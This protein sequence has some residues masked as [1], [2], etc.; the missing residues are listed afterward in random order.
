MEYLKLLV[1][2]YRNDIK[3]TRTV[4]FYSLFLISLFIF[5]PRAHAVD[6]DRH[7]VVSMYPSFSSSYCNQ[8]SDNR[9]YFSLEHSIESMYR[10]Y[11]DANPTQP[12]YEK[13]GAYSWFENNNILSVYADNSVTNHKYDMVEGTPYWNH[14]NSHLWLSPVYTVSDCLAAGMNVQEIPSGYVFEGEYVCRDVG[15]NPDQPSDGILSP[16]AFDN[17]ICASYESEG[18]ADSV[19]IEKSKI[20]PYHFFLKKSEYLLNNKEIRIVSCSDDN[21]EETDCTYDHVLKRARKLIPNLPEERFHGLSNEFGVYFSYNVFAYCKMIP[22]EISVE[23][24]TADEVDCR[25]VNYIGTSESGA[26]LPPMPFEEDFCYVK[27]DENGEPEIS[28]RQWCNGETGENGDYK[29]WTDGKAESCD[30]PPEIKEVVETPEKVITTVEDKVYETEADS[31]DVTITTTT[32]KTTEDKETG[33]ISTTPPITITITVPKGDV[34]GGNGNN[35]GG[36]S[37]PDLGTVIPVGG[38]V[39]PFDF[40]EQSYKPNAEGEDP[41]YWIFDKHFKSLE[42]SPIQN[43]FGNMNPFGTGDYDFPVFDIDLNVSEDLNFGHYTI[44]LQAVQIG[45]KTINLIAILRSVILLLVALACVREI[46]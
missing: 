38:G 42:N 26:S 37:G 29:Y 10:Y 34:T 36:S 8:F 11:A 13:P 2:F 20:T 35:S 17:F 9:C 46:F 27:T 45:D 15:Q 39:E 7:L 18:L 31:D 24:I 22:K 30:A 28:F 6:T 40:Y 14:Y 33:E 4:L 5:A 1:R 25:K 3:T 16:E 32:E 12:K 41:L 21:G 43:L 19:F 23:D 44:D